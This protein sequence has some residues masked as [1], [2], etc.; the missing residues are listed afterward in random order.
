VF[1]FLKSFKY[2][3]CV[4]RKKVTRT[5]RPREDPEAALLTN[6]TQP[7]RS[8]ADERWESILRSSGEQQKEGNGTQPAPVEAEG[9]NPFAKE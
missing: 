1:Y 3:S 4:E 5:L 9:T 8:D 2:S 6:A 7:S